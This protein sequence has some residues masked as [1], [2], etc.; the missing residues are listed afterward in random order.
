MV[1]TRSAAPF[2]C[3]IG[4]YASQHGAA[5][6][7]LQHLRKLGEQGSAILRVSTHLVAMLSNKNEIHPGTCV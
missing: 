5:A 4:K 7:A 2:Q 1:L 3:E 6:A